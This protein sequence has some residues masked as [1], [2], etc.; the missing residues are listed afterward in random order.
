MIEQKQ[1]NLF[2][3]ETSI[4]IT[5]KVYTK[6]RISDRC[7]LDGK[8]CLGAFDFYNNSDGCKF[9]NQ[10]EN[11]K[12]LGKLRTGGKRPGFIPSCQK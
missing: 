12:Y 5:Y 8:P 4:P 11:Y 3:E 1:L 9:W 7:L 10:C 6:D 2:G